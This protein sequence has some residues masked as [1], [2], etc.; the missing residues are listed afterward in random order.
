[1]GHGHTFENVDVVKNDLNSKILELAPDNCQNY[2]NIP[3]MTAGPDI[4][5]K[6]ILDLSNDGINGMI[7]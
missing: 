3:I 6:S 4:G 1:M 7:V 2:K 5:T